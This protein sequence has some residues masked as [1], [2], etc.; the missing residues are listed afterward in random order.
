MTYG[1]RSYKP[2][3][4]IWKYF[5]MPVQLWKKL[6]III[7]ICIIRNI[8]CVRPSDKSNRFLNCR[9]NTISTYLHHKNTTC[10]YLHHSRYVHTLQ[11]TIKHQLGNTRYY[12][13]SG[14]IGKVVAS[15]AEGCRVDSRQ[16]LHRFILY[17]ERVAQE[18]VS[19]RRWG[20]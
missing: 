15:Y 20:G 10:T 12:A 14:R 3:I 19:L 2:K 5:I 6:I 4:S 16:R 9:S 13:L 7:I 8:R 17:C 1:L 11:K 18:V